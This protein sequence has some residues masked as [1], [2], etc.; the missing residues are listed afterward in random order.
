MIFLLLIVAVLLCALV[1]YLPYSAGLTHIETET[2]SKPTEIKKKKDDYNGYVPPDEILRR[3]EEESENRGLRARAS[4]LKDRI[5]VTSE[6][7]PIKIRLNQETVL[8]K[9]HE[10]VVSDGDPNKYDYDLDEL[11]EEE[12][13]GAAQKQ[14]EEFYSHEKI[15]GDKEAMV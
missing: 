6:D 11:I 5:N 13:R 8:R 10:K 7:M 9:R 14:A 4:A 12:T 3:E 15:G 1:L 2:R